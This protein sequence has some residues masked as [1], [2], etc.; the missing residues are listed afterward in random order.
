MEKI[1]EHRIWLQIDVDDMQFG[2]MKGKGTPDAIFIVGQMLEKF[3]AKGKNLYF[4]FVDFQ[5]LWIGFQE[6]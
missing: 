6:K 5:K 2:F 4:S 1:F 3:R